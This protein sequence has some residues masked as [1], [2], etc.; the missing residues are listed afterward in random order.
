ML[1]SATGLRYSH[2]AHRGE[3]R[4]RPMRVLLVDNEE[5]H[6]DTWRTIL[7]C[8]FKFG[9]Y[10][11]LSTCGFTPTNVNNTSEAF[12]PRLDAT[13]KIGAVW[14]AYTY[15]VEIEKARIRNLHPDRGNPFTRCSAEK[16]DSSEAGS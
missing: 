14:F 11:M 5:F 10:G 8:V 2:V 16:F 7:I 15:A 6:G 13:S 12:K 4:I 3:I 9:P 1:L